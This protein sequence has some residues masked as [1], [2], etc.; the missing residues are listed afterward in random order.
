MKTII[1]TIALLCINAF[2]QNKQGPLSGQSS[3]DCSPN[4]LANS[5][6]VQFVCKTAIDEETSKKISPFVT[7]GTSGIGS[8]SV[9]TPLP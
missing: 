1:L 8:S 7:P 6:G 9:Q 4:I 3:G 5:G 2:A